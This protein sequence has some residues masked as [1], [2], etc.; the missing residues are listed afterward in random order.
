MKDTSKLLLVLLL[1]CLGGSRRLPAD[2]L[3]WQ[4]DYDKAGEEAKTSHAP[5]LLDFS[6]TW[7]GPC[8]MMEKTTFVDR[9]VQ[10]ALAGYVLVRIDIDR[11]AALAARYGVRAVPT[12]I[13]LNPF[14]D[15]V[16]RRTGYADAA[17]FSRWLQAAANLPAAKAKEPRSAAVAR[18]IREL[19]QSLDVPDA[20]ARDR[21]LAEL[22]AIYC[23]RGSRGDEKAAGQPASPDPLT[24]AVVNDDGSGA[25]LVEGELGDFVQRHPALAA[26]RLND[27]RLAVRILFSTLFAAKAGADFQF[28][29]WAPAAARATLAEAWA[30]RLENR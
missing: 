21:A 20:V 7:C 17:A 5:V 3:P 27:A 24:A 13:L 30:K 15:L 10:A 9:G 1:C 14:G 22:L 4:F 8:Q 28:D 12:C 2:E 23:A 6:A 29:P 11:D 16:D 26:A 19:G 18:G 25:K